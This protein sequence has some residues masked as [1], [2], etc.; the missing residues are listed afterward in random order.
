MKLYNSAL[1]QI[2][3]LYL[4]GVGGVSLPSRALLCNDT[5]I[6][7]ECRIYKTGTASAPLI[8]DQHLPAL[9]ILCSRH[10]VMN[11]SFLIDRDEMFLEVGLVTFVINGLCRPDTENNVSFMVQ[12][13]L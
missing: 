8:T 10:K 5:K 13:S 6:L 9:C 3:V 7:E 12:L 2:I 11:I 4:L 1:F